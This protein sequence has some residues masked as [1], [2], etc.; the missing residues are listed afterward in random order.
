MSDESKSGRQ[1]ISGDDA[2]QLPPG[3]LNLPVPAP[4]AFGGP[5]ANQERPSAPSAPDEVV[6]NAWKEYMTKGFSNNQ[7][8]F[9][10]V[11]EAFMRPYKL[12]V[13]MYQVMFWIGILGFL[14]AIGLSIWKGI[15][16]GV[17][18][19]S[20]SAAGFLG[21]FVSRPLQ[22]LEQNLM[23]ITWLGLIYNTYWTR[24]MYTNDLKVIQKELDEITKT[25]LDQ[26]NALVDKQTELHKKRPNPE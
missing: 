2:A 7:K 22:S 14:L 16:Y 8:M 9:E 15:A 1:P 18:F 17:L 21:Y 12:T 6:Y 5:A 4:Q 19:G 23:L 13:R 24:L 10:E 3:V 20:L 11:L 26:I 25:S